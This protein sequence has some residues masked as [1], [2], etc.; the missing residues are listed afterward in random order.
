MD[1]EIKISKNEIVRTTIIEP[2]KETT[3]AA[4]LTSLKSVKQQSNDTM[5]NFVNTEKV[6]CGSLN[7]S[8]KRKDQNGDSESNSDDETDRVDD[9]HAI[10]K[11]R[12]DDESVEQSS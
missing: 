2:V 1:I 12:S 6:T 7:S 8:S 3:M 9:D 4:L 10:K 5:T 11:L